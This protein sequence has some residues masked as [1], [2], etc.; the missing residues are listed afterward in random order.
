MTAAMAICFL[1]GP[2]E[3]LIP[4]L[5]SVEWSSKGKRRKTTGTGRMQYLKDVNRRWKNGFREDQTAKP[6]VVEKAGAKPAA[7]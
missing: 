2:D 6:R 1:P 5:S 3:M 4:T 7:K